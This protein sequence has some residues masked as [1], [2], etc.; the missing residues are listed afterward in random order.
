[1]LARDGSLV[2][3]AS[4]T[5]PTRIIAAADDP[6]IPASDLARLASSPALDIVRTAPGGHCGFFDGARGGGWLEREVFAT[7]ESQRR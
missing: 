7:L 6:I 1:M 4:L 3:H 2:D 5:V